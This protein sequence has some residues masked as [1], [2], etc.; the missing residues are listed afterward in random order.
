[1]SVPYRFTRQQRLLKAAEYQSVFKQAYK[2]SDRYLVVLARN[3]GQDGARLGLAI[4]KKRIKLA[5]GRNRLKRLIRESFRQNQ[6]ALSGLDC[7]ILAR[8]GVAH[9]N[10]QTLLVSLARHWQQILSRCKNS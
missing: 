4:S 2:S 10:N 5:V 3:N 9:A 6:S 7:V 1:M 8:T